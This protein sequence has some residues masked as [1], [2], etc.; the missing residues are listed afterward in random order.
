MLERLGAGLSDVNL[1]TRVE[2]LEQQP[3]DTWTLDAVNVDNSDSLA[4][5]CEK[6]VMAIPPT[7]EALSIVTN[8]SQTT[9]DVLSNVQTVNYW[10]YTLLGLPSCSPR[11]Y[12]KCIAPDNLYFKAP[13]EGET[14]TPSTSVPN[15]YARPE[16]GGPGVALFN[17][18][19]LHFDE[20]D[21]VDMIR[22][23][24]HA[25]F[26][27]EPDSYEIQLY[28]KW[29]YFPHVSPQ[30]MQEGFYH[31]LEALQGEQNIY[32]TG[33]FRDFELV[34]NSM[35][36][37]ADLLDT[38][39]PQSGQGEDSPSAGPTSEPTN[40]VSIVYLVICSFLVRIHANTCLTSALNI[41]SA[42]KPTIFKTNQ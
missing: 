31:D 29:P 4:Y 37:T 38:Y 22:G 20:Q 1:S 25:L 19:A 15:V 24:L 11:D 10:E 16:A 35:R 17:A 6:V 28:Q 18:G 33:G 7:T 36:T 3:D 27:Y 32:F 2:R 39:F 41:L 34:D 8:L 13:A 26:G 21:V 30:V 14:T 42:H 12:L 9:Q 23:H 5:S 40:D